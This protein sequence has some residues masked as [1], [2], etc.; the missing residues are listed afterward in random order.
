MASKAQADG[1]GAPRASSISRRRAA[2]RDRSGEAYMRRRNEIIQ[3]AA[4]VFRNKGYQ[5]STLADVSEA[6]GVDRASLYFY[7][8]S[9]EEIFDEI[10]TDVVKANL[11]IAEEIR[12]SSEPAPAK[13]RRLVSQLMS[14][15]AEHY[16][17]LYVYLQENLAHVAE[18]RRGWAEELR[19]VNRRYEAAVQDIVQQGVDEGS[20]R[21]ITDAR[22]VAYG[23][24][25][26]VS[27]THRWFSPAKSPVDARTIG[28][29]YAEILLGGLEVREGA[30]PGVAGR[31]SGQPVPH[32]DVARLANRFADAA[33]PTYDTLSVP[34]ARAL[35]EE[36][37]RLQREPQ[38]VAFVED[39][40]LEG[41]EGRLPARV[42]RP[43]GGGAGHPVVVYLHGGGWTLGSLRAADEPCRALANASGCVVV[44]VD[45]RRAP[46]TKFPGPLEDCVSA[47]RWALQRAESLGGDGRVVLLGDSA[48][49][50]LAAATTLRLR[51]LGGPQV[52]AQLLV[53]PTLAPAS[54]TDFP[55]YRA[56]ADG[57]L[58]TRR[59]LDW[60]WE[61]YL[62]SPRDA[63]DPLA[64]P[65]HAADLSAL[66]PATV[67]VAELD[68]LHDEGVAYARRL[69]AAGVPTRLVEVTGA[70]H[71][72]WWMDAALSQAEE[73]TALLAEVL[74]AL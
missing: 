29:S 53:Y 69:E 54:T 68:P 67:V 51:E 11:A 21:G 30:R 49:G 42:Y 56:F 59:E 47:A 63:G 70:A 55:S 16:P 65:L 14:S 45:Y 18:E 66:P 8:G 73:L 25:G 12:D 38:P 61:H 71:G 33:V 34:Q 39:V 19:G 37:T 6:V 40:L 36:V 15:Y 44:S 72:Y 7:V 41:A 26:M 35:L 24:M 50:N 3:A 22:V 1:V 9:K 48:G 17:F 4:E 64:A 58:I 74:A 13:L 20:L 62:R 57:P 46:E 10:V 60:F 5:A 32:P 31:P 27:W 2:A 43:G 52:A 23:V 28:E